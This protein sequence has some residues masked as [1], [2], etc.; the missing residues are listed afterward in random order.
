MVQRLQIAPFVHGNTAY[1][2]FLVSRMQTEELQG[3][4]HQKSDN[5]KN[6]IEGLHQTSFP[7]LR[8]AGLLSLQTFSLCLFTS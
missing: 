7:E 3:P 1:S 5:D 4:G 8:V 6:V 2:L